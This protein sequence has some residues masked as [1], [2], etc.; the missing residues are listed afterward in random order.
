[1]AIKTSYYEYEIVRIVI[2][3][4]SY[5]VNPHI[6]SKHVYIYKCSDKTCIL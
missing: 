1:M 2:C 3:R 6:Y 4:R 5:K